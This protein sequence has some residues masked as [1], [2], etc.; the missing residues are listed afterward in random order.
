MGRTTWHQRWLRGKK[1]RKGQV[2][3]KTRRVGWTWGCFWTGWEQTWL[4]AEGSTQVPIPL[5]TPGNHVCDKVPRC[6]PITQMVCMP[7]IVS[8]WIYIYIVL[9]TLSLNVLLPR[10]II[11]FCRVGIMSSALH[12]SPEGLPLSSYI[13]IRQ[14]TREY[15]SRFRYFKQG[16]VLER[17]EL[18]K[19]RERCWRSKK[20]EEVIPRWEAANMPGLEPMNPL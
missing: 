4:H 20:E 1:S 2:I 6:F 18:Q 5:L 17:L 16:N 13:C 8:P 14:S 11:D 15:G 12:P 9:F 7:F 3:Q 10:E 19:E